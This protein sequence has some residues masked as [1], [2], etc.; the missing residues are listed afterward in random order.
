MS[1]FCKFMSFLV[2][3][4]YGHFIVMH[5]LIIFKLDSG[6]SELTNLTPQ[7]VTIVLQTYDCSTFSCKNFL[8][9]WFTHVS[10]QTFHNLL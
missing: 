3:W 10:E 2:V 9:E 1:L 8:S 4:K 5:F 6:I 7:L